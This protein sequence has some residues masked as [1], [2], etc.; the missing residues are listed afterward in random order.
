MYLCYTLAVWLR[1]ILNAINVAPNLERSNM[2][3]GYGTFQGV[4]ARVGL[5]PPV[6]DLLA[7]L[8]A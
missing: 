6:P 2:F 3:T 4:I 8:F 1:T 5:S 7:D